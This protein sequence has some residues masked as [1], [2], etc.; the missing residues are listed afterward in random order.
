MP[1]VPP[2]E[3]A[4]DKG[5][6]AESPSGTAAHGDATTV[7]VSFAN[8]FLWSFSDINQINVGIT[9]QGSRSIPALQ[10]KEPYD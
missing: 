10:T 8:P 6:R 7:I 9:F 2:L 1:D 3:P 5:E 4:K